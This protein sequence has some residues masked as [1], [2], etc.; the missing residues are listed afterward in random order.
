MD[1]ANL[2]LEMKILMSG[3]FSFYLKA[4]QHHWNV[5]GPFFYQYH[6]FFGKIYTDVHA[7]VDDFAE[8]IR[9]L[10][11]YPPGT[12]KDL[13]QHTP[14]MSRP[15]AILDASEMIN[16]LI[17]GNTVII[18]ALTKT[19]ESAELAEEY[20]LVSFLESRLE[21]HEK[22]RWQLSATRG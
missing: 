20:G 12:L 1:R 5:T 7:S 4:H 14:L 2:I 19:R 21:Y 18:A 17:A 8:H 11:D 9:Q 10:G 6:E 22:L 16:D 13:E 3:V 15:K